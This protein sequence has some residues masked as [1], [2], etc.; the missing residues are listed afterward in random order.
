[1][2]ARTKPN[3]RS[4]ILNTYEYSRLYISRRVKAYAAALH[5]LY[6]VPMNCVLGA[7]LELELESQENDTDREKR[8]AH[9]ARNIQRSFDKET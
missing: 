4:L 7:M 1:M 5:H 9:R 2:A 3:E 8:L 6:D